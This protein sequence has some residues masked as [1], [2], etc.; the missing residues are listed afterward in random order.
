MLGIVIPIALV[1]ANPAWPLAFMTTTRYWPSRIFQLIS[2]AV[3]VELA[4]ATQNRCVVG[5]RRSGVRCGGSR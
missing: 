5:A 3:R 2:A 1:E 4:W